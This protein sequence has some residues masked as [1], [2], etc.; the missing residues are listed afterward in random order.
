MPITAESPPNTKALDAPEI[1]EGEAELLTFTKGSNSQKGEFDV[2]KDSL[3][4]LQLFDFPGMTVYVNGEEI[5]HKNNECQGQD[6]CFGLISFFLNEGRNEFVAVL[7]NTPVRK[8]ANAI[9]LFSLA[10]VT[11]LYFGLKN[12]KFKKIFG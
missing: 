2:K 4:R 12:E 9:S 6:Y 10:V 1:L 5:Q 8:L 7:K 11:Y 3:V